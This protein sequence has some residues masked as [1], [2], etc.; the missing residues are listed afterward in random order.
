MWSS[1]VE[2][3]PISLAPTQA[4]QGQAHVIE[5]QTEYRLQN[6]TPVQPPAAPYELS[7]HYHS[8]RLWI[9]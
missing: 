7:E 4:P 3:Y 1:P 6:Y 2:L 9:C 5:P 8:R